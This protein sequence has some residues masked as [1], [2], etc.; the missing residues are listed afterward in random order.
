MAGPS[1]LEQRLI[2]ITSADLQRVGEMSVPYEVLKNFWY[3]IE[4]TTASKGYDVFAAWP[5]I[6][7]ACRM[8]RVMLALLEHQQLRQLKQGNLMD[9]M[10]AIAELDVQVLLEKEKTYAGSWKRRGGIGAFM[11]LARKWDRI[12]NIVGDYNLDEVLT[13]NVGDIA[14]DIADLRRYLLLVETEMM[15]ATEPG[16]TYT[17]PDGD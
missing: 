2:T 8:F 13:A 12:E 11:M 16:S 9:N 10:A 4:N 15:A 3:S 14:D 17:N 6:T 5:G 7:T 1:S